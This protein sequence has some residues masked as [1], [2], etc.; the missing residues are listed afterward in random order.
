M[1]R[2]SVIL[3]LLVVLALIMS[4]VSCSQTPAPTTTIAPTT[5]APPATTTA[6]P[7]TTSAPSTSKPPTTAP[8]TSAAVNVIQLKFAC[9]YNPPHPQANADMVWI[10]RIEKASNGRV[11]IV[12]YGGGSLISSTEYYSELA[13][14][15]ADIG[16]TN[17]GYGKSGFTLHRGSLIFPYG[18]TD[19]ADRQQVFLDLMAKFPE[20]MKEYSDTHIMGLSGMG[21]YQLICKKPIRTVADLK[22]LSLRT[23]ADY[24]DVVKAWGAQGVALSMGDTYLA[25]QKGTVDGALAPIET[26]VSQHFAEVNKYATM[27]QIS[28]MAYPGRAMNLNSWNKL[29][30]D[31]QKIFDDN[32]KFYSDEH[33]KQMEIKNQEAIAEGKKLGMEFITPSPT[34]LAKFYE[35]LVDTCL[36]KAA[37]LD[38]KG[39]PGTTIYKETRS[40]VDKYTK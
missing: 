16:Y 12:F 24:A 1:K 11:D 39:Y 4:I 9:P 37:E 34:E 22:G 40:L 36:K 31:I 21:E 26:L 5:S 20:I 27:I 25:M 32:Y 23:T 13:A 33:S 15:V 29:P 8:I 10:D 28:Y 14:G 35:P 6:A 38:A 30:P 18:V 3:S 2:F 19:P 7:P 17:P